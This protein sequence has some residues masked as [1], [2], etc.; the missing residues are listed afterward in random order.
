MNTFQIDQ[1]IPLF[2]QVVGAIIL[3]VVCFQ[4]IRNVMEWRR[5]NRAPIEKYV[6]KL[7]TKR[8]HV[9][10]QEMARTNYYVTFEWNGQRTEFRVRAQDY[11]ALAEGDKGT[12]T[13]QGTRF[14][15]F[16]RL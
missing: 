8:T 4:I 16:E 7:V 11:A 5:N 10:G 14:L 13:F 1:L 3:G 12:V 15:S 6:A 9:F 2:V